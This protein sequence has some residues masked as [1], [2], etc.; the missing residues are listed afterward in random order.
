MANKLPL[1]PTLG[2]TLK[3]TLSEVYS[4]MGFSILLSLIWFISYLPVLIIFSV[5]V[6]SLF[7][8]KSGQFG[9]VAFFAVFGLLGAAFWNGLIAGPLTTSIYGLYQLRKVDYPSCKSFIELFKKVYWR[10]A[11]IHW[12][13]SLGIT[14]LVANLL[15]A[16]LETGFFLK[17]AGIISLY[18]LFFIVLMPFFFHPLIY[19]DNKF[20]AVFRKSFLLVLDN[21]ALSFFF[22]ILSL[23]F[24]LLCIAIPFLLILCYGALMIYLI[25]YGFEAI[26]NKYE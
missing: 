24:F 26:Y 17:L 23:F 1:F 15:I 8:V 19:L 11:T 18:F 16:L 22:G 3:H 7:Q 20:K 12:I 14:V 21:F 25:N 10:S 5:T 2:K 13:F 4:S 6:Q 9:E